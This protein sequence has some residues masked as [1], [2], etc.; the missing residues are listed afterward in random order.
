VGGGPPKIFGKRGGEK[1]KKK[2]G[3]KEEGG[4][5]K[6]LGG[7]ELGVF[8]L[9]KIFWV[10]KRRPKRRTPL[11]KIFLGP[12]I[13]PKIFLLPLGRFPQN[14]GGGKFQNWAPLSPENGAPRLDKGGDRIF[15]AN[16]FPQGL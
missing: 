9:P 10:K 11:L 4:G 6:N 3:F 5:E 2:A 14:L 16:R 1:K 15:F 7:G 12:G 13:F 8:N